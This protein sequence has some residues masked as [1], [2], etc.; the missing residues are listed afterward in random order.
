[1]VVVFY[2]IMAMMMARM[3]P[4]MMVPCTVL[5]GFM[6]VFSSVFSGG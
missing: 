2:R 1:V 6:R 3:K 5:S 4:A